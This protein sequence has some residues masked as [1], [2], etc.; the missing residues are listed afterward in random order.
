MQMDK[1]IQVLGILHI[2]Y[3]SIALLSGAIV[4]LL[5][6]GTGVFVSRLDDA[7]TANVPAILFTVGSAIALILVIVSI[8]GIIG[9]IGLLKRKEWARILVL[10]VGFLDLLHIPLGTI[11]GIYTI[12]ALMND[13][14]IK[15]FTRQ[16]GTV[17]R[18]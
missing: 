1:H 9:G 6:F 5:F 14:A 18:T 2:V 16:T 3:S 13:E 4:F 17:V 10:V 12:W 7:Q 15:L 11:L 8:P